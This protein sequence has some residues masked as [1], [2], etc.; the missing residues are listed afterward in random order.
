MRFHKLFMIG[1]TLLLLAACQKP[2]V[3][4]ST[5]HL[6]PPAEARVKKKK[7]NIPALV[8]ATPLLPVPT[9]DPARERYTIVL[10]NV[11]VKELL[12]T[13][14]RD[15]ELNINIHP[16]IE[17]RVTI[18]AVEQTLASIL[19]HLSEQVDMRYRFKGDTLIVTPDLP[20][21][22]IYKVDY[23]NL[24]RKST[25]DMSLDLTVGGEGAGSVSTTSVNNE[26]DSEF[27][28]PLLKGIINI[29]DIEKGRAKTEK[30]KRKQQSMA[31]AIAE[32]GIVEE[33][34]KKEEEIQ[35]EEGDL[36]PVVA[37]QSTG[38]INVYATKRQ[39]K[40]VQ[41]YLD[42]VLGSALKQVLIEA[43]VVEIRLTDG[44]EKGVNWKRINNGLQGMHV[45]AG[46]PDYFE[47]PNTE[48]NTLGDIASGAM[49]AAVGGNPFFHIASRA[50]NNGYDALTASLKLL[51]KYGEVS[52][53]SSPKVIA[54]NGQPAMLK[55]VDEKVYFEVEREVEEATAD[56]PAKVTT[57]STIKTIPEGLIMAVVAQVSENGSIALHV[58]PSLTQIIGYK[59]DPVY[60]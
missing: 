31:A 49:D 46:D 21:W 57:T 38:V 24:K 59:T 9:K 25:S 41:A 17:G 45:A 3:P 39:H 36:E 54:L 28:E 4:L 7:K 1:L 48:T 43:T 58:R 29:I 22:N 52:V 40:L 37:H 44:F 10:H 20:Y 13:L 33:G 51:E 6:R 11:P 8:R 56:T 60:A 42:R 18:N 2:V 53:L 27:W 34:A 15:S 23:L 16:E 19:Q 50:Y 47:G 32:E 5:G 26:V 14:A 35:E 12:F 55:V 30:A